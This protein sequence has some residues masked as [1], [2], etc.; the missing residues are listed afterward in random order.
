MDSISPR[1]ASSFV[2]IQDFIF[3]V[4]SRCNLNC[5]YCYMYNKG[6]LSYLQQ[7]KVMPVAVVDAAIERIRAYSSASGTRRVSIILH[8]GEPL[9]A[10]QTFFRRFV[11]KANSELKPDIQP[12]FNMQ[13][14]GA[15]LDQSWLALLRE[16]DIRFGISLDGPESINDANR[17]D[18]RG[19]GSYA[20]V[21][22]AIDL[23]RA[24]S[25]VDHL[26]RGVLCVVNLDADPLELYD[27]YRCLGIGSVDFLLPDGHYDNPPA[28]LIAGSTDTPYADW[29]IRLF[30]KWFS[31]DDPTFRIPIFEGIIGAIFGAPSGRDDLGGGCNGAIVI[32]SDGTIE[33]VDVLKIC[34]D[35]FTKTH[36]NVADSDIADAYQSDLIRMYL[37]GGRMLCK[38][39]QQCPVKAVCGGGYLPH[40]YSVVNGFDNPSVYCHNLMKLIIYIQQ[41]VVDALPI[42][43]RHKLNIGPLVSN[44]NRQA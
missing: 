15:L 32:E 10:G 39:C 42:T 14:N 43:I 16:L 31:D 18:H 6:D 30:N 19:R 28:G 22:R 2:P 12:V 23:V 24:D 1:D 7:P 21:R 8:G 25:R 9:L 34:G 20:R 33:P 26:F 29:L 27:F 4:T 38:K 5:S 36:F 11:E 44:G 3:K 17:V 40:R 13:T 35:R 37:A 41:K